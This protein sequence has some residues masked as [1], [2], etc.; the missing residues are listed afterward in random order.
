MFKVG[1]KVVVNPNKTYINN[2]FNIAAIDKT[3]LIIKRVD[4]G[5]IEAVVENTDRLF[6]TN[7]RVPC[8]KHYRP[9]GTLVETKVFL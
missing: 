3:I 6:R 5:Y 4:R 2:N 9:K 8:F 1:D 7:T